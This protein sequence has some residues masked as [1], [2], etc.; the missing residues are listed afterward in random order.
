MVFFFSLQSAL[1][2]AAV[3]AAS[4]GYLIMAGATCGT[5]NTEADKKNYKLMP[6]V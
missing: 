5:N 2:E 6:Q 3:I 1:S 4:Q